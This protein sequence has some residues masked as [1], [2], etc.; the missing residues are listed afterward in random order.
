[1]KRAN[2]I[3]LAL[4]A[5][6]PLRSQVQQFFT[7]DS[8]ASITSPL[9][10]IACSTWFDAGAGVTDSL[11]GVIATDEGVGTWND[12][13]GN[14]RHATQTTDT[15]RPVYKATGGPGSKPCIQFDGTDDFLSTATHFWGS[16]DMT[17]IV[18][19]KVANA[20][21]NATETIIRKG[22]TS[23]NDRQFSY[24]MEGSA[25]YRHQGIVFKD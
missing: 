22:E 10:R 4:L 15:D 7:S 11:G 20:T 19:T 17:V 1:M 9:G 14:G 24:Q 3:I 23:T 13:S 2:F 5:C 21:R 6:L 18:V 8:L 25:T 12:Q 16:D